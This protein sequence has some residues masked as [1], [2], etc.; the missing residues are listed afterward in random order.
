MRILVAD[1]DPLTCRHLEHRLA[2]WKYE[3]VT[4]G[5]G[6]TAWSLLRGGEI[7]ILIT[8]WQMPGMSGIDLVRRIRATAMPSYV[9]VI[10]LTG[11][12]S[13]EDIVEGIGAGADDFLTKPFDKNELFVRLKTG[14][15][16]VQ[17][18]ASL[19]EQ[20]HHVRTLQGLLP[21][22]MH[23]KKI[24][25]TK[26]YWVQVEVYI[27]ERTDAQFSHGLCPECMAKYYPEVNA[28]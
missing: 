11:K 27:G 26:D 22:C 10:I 16:I 3:A 4:A 24:R 2:A 28:D 23:C 7:Q 19:K 8:D 14:E 5:D 25:N 6:E 17:L 20:I 15:R 21:I 9:Y 1:D 18:E 12:T 13:K